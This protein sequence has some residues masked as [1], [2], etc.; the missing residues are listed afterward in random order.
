MDN[1][2]SGS[3]TGSGLDENE[4]NAMIANL[5]KESNTSYPAAPSRLNVTPTSAPSASQASQTGAI[6]S[7]VIAPAAQPEI[8]PNL[9]NIKGEALSE[10]RPL[11][12]K[13][14]LAPADKFN[15]LLLMI[16]SSDDPSLVPEAHEV[17]KTIPDEARRAQAL[18]D[19]IK[20]I[21]FF[22]QNK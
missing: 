20:E 4:L 2:N 12:N 15:I 21:D 10:L 11:V 3:A 22:D 13:L 8:S 16:R 17:A 9:D 6:S 1:T 19:I 14:N 5:Q 7:P 18:L